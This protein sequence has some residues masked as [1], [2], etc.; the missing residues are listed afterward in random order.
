MATKPSFGG[1]QGANWKHSG[2]TQKRYDA[3]AKAHAA[4]A[5]LRKGSGKAAVKTATKSAAK[6]R[7][8][9]GSWANPVGRLPSK[10]SEQKLRSMIAEDYKRLRTGNYGKHHP[11]KIQSMIA[12]NE[13]ILRSWGKL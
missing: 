1:K 5:A 11:L 6:V 8:P 13:R 12:D 10:F 2:M 3:L 7:F 9:K 4:A